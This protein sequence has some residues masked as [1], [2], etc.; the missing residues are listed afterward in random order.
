M[1]AFVIGLLHAG[2]GTTFSGLV[3]DMLTAARSVLPPGDTVTIQ[4][5][6]GTQGHYA[7]D[8]TDKLSDDAFTLAN[9]PAVNVIVAAGGPQS[10]IAAMDATAAAEPLPANRKPVVFTSVADPVGLGLVDSL[11]NPGRNLTGVAGQTSENDAVRLKLLH[12]FLFLTPAMAIPAG[13]NVGV[14][15]NP[16]RKGNAKEYQALKRVAR[17]LG[18]NLVPKRAARKPK[19]DDAFTAF[20]AANCRGVVV[21][22]DA[23]F[24]N[25]RAKVI[26][27]AKG[28]NPPVTCIPTIYQWRQFIERPAPDGG[29]ISYG[30][31]IV[32]AYEMAG[33]Y[34]TQCC[35]GERPEEMPC[36][37]PT[38]FE[39]VVNTVTAA[40]FTTPLQVPP[41][42]D[43]DTLGRIPVTRYP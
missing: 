28:A 37:T 5:D 41:Y 33:R 29:L 19:I 40:N 12:A 31:S 43:H 23:L 9:D 11:V 15:I 17:R 4:T 27:Q 36:L 39:L 13:G 22:A 21:M 6:G 42:L 16:S 20:R 7:D 8:D 26:N 30:P 2:S 10:A 24:N 34:A 25:N 32:E 3:G 18:L 38:R 1:T 14:L 35:L